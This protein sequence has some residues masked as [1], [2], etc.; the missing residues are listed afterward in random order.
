MATLYSA[1]NGWLDSFVSFK[2][3]SAATYREWRP[4][5]KTA[6]VRRASSAFSMGRQLKVKKPKVCI[7]SR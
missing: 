1:S 2:D 3:D 5:T 7:K 6:I 4:G